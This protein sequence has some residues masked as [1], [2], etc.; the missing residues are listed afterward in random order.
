VSQALATSD[1]DVCLTAPANGYTCTSN[2]QGAYS[3]ELAGTPDP[4]GDTVTF[5]MSQVCQSGTIVDTTMNV[6]LSGSSITVDRLNSDGSL[7]LVYTGTMSTDCTSVTGH[8]GSPPEDT[9]DGS[10][11]ATIAGGGTLS[12]GGCSLG[13]SWSES[14][15]DCISTWARQ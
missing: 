10:W 3:C 7:N 11:N 5:F 12:G 14:E 9:S 8:Y 15:S 1:S 2:D 13:I 6:T 4:A